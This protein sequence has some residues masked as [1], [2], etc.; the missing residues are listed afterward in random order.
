MENEQINDNLKQS[1]R[2][3]TIKM[4]DDLRINL[5]LWKYKQAF[6][7]STL[8]KLCLCNA[9]DYCRWEFKGHLGKLYIV[10][11]CAKNCSINRS[12]WNLFTTTI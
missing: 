2:N 10:E 11:Q 12:K 8:Y 6:N 1:S 7:Y 5:F 4:T 3:H 9:D